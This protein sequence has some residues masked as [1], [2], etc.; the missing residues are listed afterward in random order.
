M[1]YILYTTSFFTSQWLLPYRLMTKKIP[2]DI[3]LDSLA[4]VSIYHSGQVLYSLTLQW[5][6][7]E[8]DLGWAMQKS[9]LGFVYTWVNV[10]LM[11]IIIDIYKKKKK[12]S[13]L[14][15]VSICHS[16]WVLYSLTLQWRK[17]EVDCDNI[18]IQSTEIP[19]RILQ[20]KC[21]NN[22]D[23]LL[24]YKAPYLKQKHLH[25]NYIWNSFII[26]RLINKTLHT[27]CLKHNYLLLFTFLLVP[28]LMFKL[29][30]FFWLDPPR[31]DKE[32]VNTYL[33]WVII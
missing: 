23:N 17:A 7:S 9:V 2:N 25:F 14:A 16:W 11:H 24:L 20:S 33:S 3:P 15:I 32:I 21:Y 18:L 13:A 19:L 30:E 27:L 12:N 28:S 22:S 5:R 4:I 6:K 8:F 26:Y 10:L 1:C 29:I 31:V